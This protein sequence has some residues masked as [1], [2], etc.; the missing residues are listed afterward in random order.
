MQF[1][2]IKQ[3]FVPKNNG[4]MILGHEKIRLHITILKI[5]IKGL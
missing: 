4:Y 1:V 2:S 3:K 5:N